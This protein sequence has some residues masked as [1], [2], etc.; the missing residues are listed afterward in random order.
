MTR[1]ETEGGKRCSVDDC[2]TILRSVYIQEKSPNQR[3]TIF[4]VASDILGQV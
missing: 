3:L 2:D 1:N 4:V